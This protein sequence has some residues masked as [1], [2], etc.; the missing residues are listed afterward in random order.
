VIDPRLHD[1]EKKLRKESHRLAAV[2]MIR[3]F[4]L[5]FKNTAARQLVFN[6]PGALIRPPILYKEALDQ[7]FL[8][9]EEDK[10]SL[11]QGDVIRT[12]RA[13]HAGEK[14]GED[15]LFV[16]LSPTC[17][18]VPNR[19]EW[20]TLLRISPITKSTE[21]YKGFLNTLLLFKRTHSLYLPPLNNDPEI[22][23]HSVSFD[24]F[25]QIPLADALSSERVASLSLVGW[26]I[27]GSMVRN[28]LVR[29]G[30]GEVKMR[31]SFEG[32]K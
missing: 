15:T 7:G 27:F 21:D 28:I 11:L 32:V 22:L 12:N 13:F 16:V 6:Q 8:K 25:A 3:I 10:F 17:D 29:A 4:T 23:G 5:E 2:K 26:R 24:G 19:Q 30:Q 20:T 14:I 1:L 9:P 31:S 18:L